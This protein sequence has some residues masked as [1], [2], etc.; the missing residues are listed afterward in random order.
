MR[1]KGTEHLPG[2]DPRIQSGK[3]L[4]CVQPTP[5]VSSACNLMSEKRTRL[6]LISRSSRGVQ[7]TVAARSR[8]AS[9]CSPR[10]RVITAAPSEKPIPS[11]GAEGNMLERY[12][13]VVC[14]SSVAP[15]Q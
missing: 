6:A 2:H 15:E 12:I 1:V 4:L 13:V 14:V 8:H 5:G 11:N 3:N 7:R 9:P 10:Y